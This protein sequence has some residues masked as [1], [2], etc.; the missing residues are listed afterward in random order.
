MTE[1]D[2]KRERKSSRVLRFKKNAFYSLNIA[3]KLIIINP[4]HYWTRFFFT[5]HDLR[6]R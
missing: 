1:I 3:Y 6:F 2:R 4:G 5:H